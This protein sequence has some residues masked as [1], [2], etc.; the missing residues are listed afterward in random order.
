MAAGIRARG[1]SCSAVVSS[2]TQQVDFCSRHAAHRLNWAIC[3]HT[4]GVVHRD[5]K[6]ANIKVTP[7]GKAKVLDFGLAK[8]LVR[9]AAGQDLSESPTL[10]RDATETYVRSFPSPGDPFQISTGGGSE[11]VWAPNGR[12][13]F[14]RETGGDRVMSVSFRSE[15][16]LRVGRPRQ[17]FE[18]QYHGAPS[19]GRNYDISTDGARFLMLQEA[20]TQSLSTP[21]LPCLV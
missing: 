15:Q 16:T 5:L 13:L 19:W 7:E 18:G 17:L 6:P 2:S 20:D 4:I 21:L 12:E 11:P 3:S 1:L 8:A 9:E 10:T 14:Y